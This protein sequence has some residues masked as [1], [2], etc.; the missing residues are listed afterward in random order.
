MFLPKAIYCRIFQA[1]FRMALPILPYREPEILSK[2]SDLGAVLKIEKSRSVLV[3]TDK[4]I[5]A[6]GLLAPVEETLRKCGIPFTVYKETQPNPTV[7]NVE[8]ALAVYRKNNCDTRI[9]IGG[10]SAMDCAK[11]GG[12]RVV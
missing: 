10:G 6:N 7:Q 4:G 11:V 2:C 1:A 5:V 8:D 3:V 12:A 9:A